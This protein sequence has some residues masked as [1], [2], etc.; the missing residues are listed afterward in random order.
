M[1][2]IKC[3]HSIL[4]IYKYY[5]THKAAVGA[6]AVALVRG[7]NDGVCVGVWVNSYLALKARENVLPSNCQWDMELKA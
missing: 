4:K 6:P 7:A 3:V 1:R 2:A 5:P